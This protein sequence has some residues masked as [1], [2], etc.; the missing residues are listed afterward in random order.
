MI[1]RKMIITSVALGV[2]AIS[3]AFT[4]S[5]SIFINEYDVRS[6]YNR[7]WHKGV[8]D[9]MLNNQESV[10]RFAWDLFLAIIKPGVRDISRKFSSL[11]LLDTTAKYGD[12]N[13][14]TIWETMLSMDEMERNSILTLPEKQV[15][16]T[17][18]KIGEH[19]LSKD[20]ADKNWLVDQNGSL[21][22][23]EIRLNHIGGQ[24]IRTKTLYAK[25]GIENYVNDGNDQ[26]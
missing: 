13:T 26:I 23:Y 19:G 16:P 9:P 20:Q 25:K 3:S 15:L 12:P 22:W 6:G 7:E 14:Q 2:F 21:V 24:F 4:F 18:N 1:N 10:D 5:D 11:E 17:V 8:A